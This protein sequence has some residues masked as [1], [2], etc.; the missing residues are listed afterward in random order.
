VCESSSSGSHG[1]KGRNIIAQGNALGIQVYQRSSPE[2][3]THPHK[4][5]RPFRACAG[6]DGPFPRGVAPGYDV[7][8]FQ[9][10]E[11]Q[12]PEEHDG[13]IQDIS[14][15]IFISPASSSIGNRTAEGIAGVESCTDRKVLPMQSE[16]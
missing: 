5:S 12:K 13:L 7:S 16:S 2:R 9:G 4:V 3:A 15:L 6:G 11:A 1:L 8:P 14:T 10:K